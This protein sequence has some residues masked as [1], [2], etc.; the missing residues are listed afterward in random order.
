MSGE[1]TIEALTRQLTSLTIRLSQ[2][3]GELQELRTQRT[4]ANEDP[5]RRNLAQQLKRGDRV[6][7]LSK[8]R[9]PTDW[10]GRWTDTEIEIERTATV[11]H[12]VKDQVWII[13]DNG[14]KTWRATH[15]L[16]LL[17]EE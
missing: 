12:T 13:T 16:E 17:T 5:D 9:R 7:I 4:N 11:T 1:D 3:E 2:V 15:N 10:T 14:T 8:I 6:R